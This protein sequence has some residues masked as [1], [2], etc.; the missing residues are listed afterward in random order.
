MTS[1][2]IAFSGEG[3]TDHRFLSKIIERTVVSL[4]TPDKVRQ[5]VD[6]L[7]P[8]SLSRGSGSEA[9][10]I[11]ALG[12]QAY[13]FHCFIIHADADASTPT[14]ALAE[15]YAPGV[16]QLLAEADPRC[17][18]IIPLI[19]VHM[20]EAWMLADPDALLRLLTTP[21]TARELDLPDATGA[22]RKANPKL[23]LTEVLANAQRHLTRKNYR[24]D[25][26]D[27]YTLLPD[28]I[29]LER[30]DLLPSYQQF[31]QHLKVALISLNLLH[32]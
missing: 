14:A 11:F 7:A 8:I 21:L 15:R 12:K 1:L 20:T 16:D 28:V 24:I 9:D 6:V 25:L 10:R 3:P 19:P 31:K 30:L 13:G 26:A 27:L 17:S 23:F 18:Q 4:L 5:E 2:T 22:E 29:P 32:E